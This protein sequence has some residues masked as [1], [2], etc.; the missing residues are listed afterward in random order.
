MPTVSTASFKMISILLVKM[1]FFQIFEG[2]L[3]QHDAVLEWILD[4][5]GQD[6]I[7]LVTM[8]MFDKLIEEHKDVA[9]FVHDK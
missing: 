9:V 7:E 3:E 4:T 2:N 8:P 1:L 6:E 5:H